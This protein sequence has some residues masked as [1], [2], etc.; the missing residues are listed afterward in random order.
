MRFRGMGNDPAT[1][2]D[3]A[4]WPVVPSRI[5]NEGGGGGSGAGGPRPTVIPHVVGLEAPYGWP[6]ATAT[7]WLLDG[8]GLIGTANTDLARLR[9]ELPARNVGVV[10]YVAFGGNSSLDGNAYSPDPTFLYTLL[11]NGAPIPG[12][13]EHGALPF[14]GVPG[15]TYTYAHIM[16]PAGAVLQGRMRQVL[17]AT[18]S[19][20][21][22]LQGWYWPESQYER[23]VL[24][25]GG[26]YY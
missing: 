11:V 26:G 2:K 6:P 4:T 12:W 9:L 20:A 15:V 22:A 23:D 5:G 8:G 3:Q 17:G 14:A 21:M 7:Q 18:Q 10:K 16:L 24:R 19:M 13:N 1:P 25:T